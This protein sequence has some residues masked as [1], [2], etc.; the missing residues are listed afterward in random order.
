MRPV[1]VS[2]CLLGLKVRYDGTS[3]P[4]SD[5]LPDDV[6]AIPVCPEVLGGLPT[7]RP[8]SVIESGSGVDVLS[9]KAKVFSEE[10]VEVTVNFVRGAEAVLKVAKISGAKEAYL[11]ARSPSCDES[12]GVTAALLKK[13]SITVHPVE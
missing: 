6:I 13:N 12:F 2:A 3:K 1:L 11:K 4:R 8:K 7:P 9:G 5:F 10:G